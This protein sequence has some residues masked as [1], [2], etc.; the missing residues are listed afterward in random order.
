M[1]K[2]SILKKRITSLDYCPHIH[3]LFNET[4]LQW[5]VLRRIKYYHLPCLNSSLNLSCFYDDNYFCLCYKF[6]QKRLANC[7]E[8]HHNMTM[9]SLGKNECHNQ[10]E[11]F[12]DHP[13]CP[14][15]SMCL[16]KPCF[17]GILCQLRESGFGLSLDG[18]L[19]YHILPNSSITHQPMIIIISII[20]TIIYFI[21]GLLNGLIS[22]ITFN[23]KTIQEVGCGIY[24]FG[25]SI[26]TLLTSIIFGLKYWILVY[27]HMGIL[28]NKVFLSI[29]CYSIDFMLRLCLNMDQWLN[30][31]V[32]VERAFT[33]IQGASF[34]KIKSKKIAK[35]MILILLIFNIGTSIHDP[36]YRNLI[37]EENHY[38]NEKR[39]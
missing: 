10:G 6:E 30:A 26:T 33:S 23:N 16:C 17:Y 2:S 21:V 8:F 13:T 18:I 24:L 28:T 11:Y 1:T 35:L 7:F 32:A 31:C 34:S 38:D 20:L 29:Q 36:I 27:S 3:E 25:S 12:Q 14:R 9:N 22:I 19:G 15:R 4:F 37:E 39:I 5:H